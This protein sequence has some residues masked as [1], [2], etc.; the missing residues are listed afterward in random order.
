MWACQPLAGS[1]L[2]TLDDGYRLE[3]SRRVDVDVLEL[4][5]LADSARVALAV[6]PTTALTLAA[7]VARGA[8]AVFLPGVSGTWVESWRARLRGEMV[9]ALRVEAAAALATDR[10]WDA[11][12]AA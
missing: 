4:L 6:D 11:R 8:A 1:Q 10:P 12:Q 9:T 2:V 5:A 3:L 7:H